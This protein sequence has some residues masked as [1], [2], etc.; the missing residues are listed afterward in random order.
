MKKSIVYWLLVFLP[1]F[2]IAQKP[3]A[4]TSMNDTKRLDILFADRYN[5]QT[6]DSSVFV[7]LAGNV[8]VQQG[9]TLFYTDSAVLNRQL[10]T[11]EAF[12]N[13]HIN[14]ADS[15]HTYAQYLKYLGK[16]KKA[17]LKTK[18]RLTDGKGTLTTEELEYD[19][20]V[21]I[22]T[23]LRGGKLVS[24]KSTLTSTEGFY[25]GDTKD[26]IFKRKV[27]MIDPDT[28]I[29][30]DTL[31]YNTSTELT[32]FT[33]PTVIYTIRDKRTIR[34]REGFYDM[35]NKRAELYKRAI[36]EDSSSTF[37]ADDMAFDD[38]TGLG[39]F[40]GNAVYR[41]K[42]TAQGFDMIA[43]NIKTNKKKDALV[44]TQKPLLIIK[45]KADTIYITADTLYS[46]RLS[47]LKKTRKVV[48]VRDSLLPRPALKKGEEDSTDKF[49][50]AYYN[51][52]I[53][54]DSLQAGGDSLF[55]SLED[56]V[57][58]L[59]K[60]P[61]VW[62]NNNQITGDTIYLYLKKKKPE[63]LYVFEN[64]LAINRVDSA[65]Y[66]NQL[67]GRT[68]N[69]LFTDGQ[70]NSMRA[71]GNAENIYYA[72][73]DY[74]KFVGVNKSSADVI[75]IFFDDSKPQKVLFLRNLDGTTYPMR[76]VN[77]DELR[78]RGFKWLSDKRPKS[79]FDILA[80]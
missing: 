1:G 6:K 55:Y 28:K 20:N 46:A 30:T 35:R 57:F 72:Q 59:F 43:N 56:S 34:T 32:T 44:A 51:V 33:A 4:D 25:Y 23:Y 68:I 63:R 78:L 73:D 17:F 22:G 71:K 29:T 79:K 76:Q 21:K 62:A 47:D 10:N 75:D 64:A 37:T 11:L 8:R 3:I 36:I 27:V 70:I 18:V 12:G 2:L 45:Q 31:Q 69:A 26:V 9:K 74:K 54:S 58:R 53:F 15:I 38:S 5:V 80:N 19:V 60:S 40:R 42:D 61:V 67:K 7:S 52:R 49:F 77:H 41:S 13:V 50:E 39:E 48:Q 65:A 66:Y 24:K 16:E 14:D